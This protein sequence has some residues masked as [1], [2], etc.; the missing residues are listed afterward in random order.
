[1]RRGSRGLLAGSPLALLVI[2]ATPAAG[3]ATLVPLPFF[4]ALTKNLLYAAAAGLMVAPIVLGG[5]RHARARLAPL[6]AR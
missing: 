1:M 6:A 3:D 5:V 2:A 4:D